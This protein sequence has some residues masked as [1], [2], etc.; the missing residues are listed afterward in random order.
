MFLDRNSKNWHNNKWMTP[1]GD[2]I[3][4]NMLVWG[5]EGNQPNNG[6]GG[7]DNVLGWVSPMIGVDYLHDDPPDVQLCHTVCQSVSNWLGKIDW[8]ILAHAQ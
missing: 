7:E 8:K 3:P 4:D 5:I 6:H 2:E 1:F